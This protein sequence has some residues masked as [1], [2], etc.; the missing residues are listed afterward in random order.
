M[1]IEL[2]EYQI[3]E[4]IEQY[5]EREYSIRDLQFDCSPSIEY[6]E[7]KRVPIKHKNGRVKKHPEHGYDLTEI[8]GYKTLY[9]DFNESCSFNLYVREASNG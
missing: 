8:K 7:P 5:L 2:C 9:V 1:K 4:A 3:M 6:Q